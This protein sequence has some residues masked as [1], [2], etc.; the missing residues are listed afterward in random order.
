MKTDAA[1]PNAVWEGT[2]NLFGVP[3]RCYVLDDGRRLINAD[4]M[5]MMYEADQSGA[6][7]DAD[8]SAAFVS[9]LKGDA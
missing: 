5:Q 7:M 9:W 3:L 8:Q 4:D 2:F 6:E 1:I